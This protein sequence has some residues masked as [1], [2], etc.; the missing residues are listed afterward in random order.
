MVV[1]ALR[2]GVAETGAAACFVGGVVLVVALGG[3][4]PADGA[5]A[6]G[7]PDL[8]QVPEPG[9]G[10]VAFGLVPVVARVG[11]D[12]VD[13][14]DQ[15]RSGSGGAQPPGVISAPGWAVP[16]GRGEGEPRRAGSGALAVVPGFGAGAAVPDGVS[17]V[18][19]DGEAPGCLGVGCGGGGQVAGQPGVDRAQACEFAGPVR[20]AGVGGQGDGQGD[21][22]GEPCGRRGRRG[23][24]TVLVLAGPGV[25]A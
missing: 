9:P 14:D 10:V 21:P 5:G 8:G 24:R 3:G 2:A 23:G 7:V 16:A 18:V 6:G 20:T 17:L 13:R 15:V 19:G 12:R 22:P 1:T 25:F 11:G 4:A